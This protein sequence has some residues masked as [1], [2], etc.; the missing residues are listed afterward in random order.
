MREADACP[1]Q[2]CNDQ[3][4][5]SD[6]PS[7]KARG[8]G[9]GTALRLLPA[10]DDV[11]LADRPP[12]LAG[13]AALRL[14]SPRTWAS[15]SVEMRRSR[16]RDGEPPLFADPAWDI[17]LEVYVAQADDKFLNVTNA[18][19]AAGLPM[20]TGHRWLRLLEA[21]EL[22]ER[23]SDARDRRVCWIR[24]TPKGWRFMTD[25]FEAQ[26]EALAQLVDNCLP[27]PI[28]QHG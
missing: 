14:L 9:I 13:G 26:V 17:L 15:Y 24:L 16:N 6:A 19:M 7:N 5:V 8:D 23:V 22:L 11:D 25:Q 12:T 20:S 4:K 1:R 27:R 18:S 10:S 2:S 21:E 28:P 3:P